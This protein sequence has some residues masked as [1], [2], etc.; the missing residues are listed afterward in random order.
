MSQEKSK[1]EDRVIIEKYT[2]YD[3]NE[4]NEPYEKS[5]EDKGE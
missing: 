2:D 1:G 3:Y 5:D 4:G